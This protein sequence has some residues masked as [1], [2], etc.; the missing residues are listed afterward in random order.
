M[1]VLVAG[2]SGVIGSRL[3]P[4]LTAVGHDV[5]ALSRGPRRTAALEAVGADIVTADALD[6]DQLLAAVRQAAPDAVVNLLTAIP[7]DVNPRHLARDFALTNRLRTEGT[8]NLME[9]ARAAGVRRIVAQGLAYGYQPG[10]GLANEDAPLWRDATPRQF[11]PVLAA[12]ESLEEQTVTAGGTVLRFGHLYGPGS[13]YAGD[14]TFTAQVRAGK[15]PLVG[16]GHA[17]FSFTHADDAATAI[18]AALDRDTRGVLNVVDDDPAPLHTWL[19]VFAAGLGAPAP[20]NAPAALARL[21]VGGWGVAFMDRLR[22]ADNARARL[23]LNWRPRY[24]S[25][26][27]GLTATDAA[28]AA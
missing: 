16:G 11:M 1:R 5:A 23:A 27:E 20:K 10:A 8:R 9:A 3:V 15:V 21:V 6:R 17:V 28:G 24:A 14:G 18:V 2:A 7:A 13:A 25:W 26:R 4:L 22:G 19:P 12:L